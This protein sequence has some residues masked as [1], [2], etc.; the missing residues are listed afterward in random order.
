[1]TG[2]GR[3]SRAVTGSKAKIRRRRASTLLGKTATFDGDA[4]ADHLLAQSA[5]A[6]RLAWRLSST[7]LG[8][9][10]ASAAALSELAD[11]LRRDGL[12][13]G[14]GVATILRSELFFSAPNLHARVADPVGFAIGTARALE[15]LDP[16]PSTLLLNEWIG[17]IGQDLFFPPN[18]GGWAGGRSW[19][20]GR[21]VVAR[22][23]YAANLIEGRLSADATP[24]DLLGLA[25]RH[26]GAKSTEEALRFY[27]DLLL[28]RPLDADVMA[29]LMRPES[30]NGTASA[31]PLGRAVA[32]LL[33]RP[34]A[35]IC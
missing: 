31:S 22:A 9:G 15:R 24:P 5:V 2:R 14:R 34:E 23:N 28:G 10:V 3:S 33:A 18:V 25:A 27:C 21:G 16:P 4:L 20:T 35:Q 32:L 1:M 12:H 8:E 19:L 26:V 13:V 17:R 7:F 29:S 30:S 11:Q 6:D